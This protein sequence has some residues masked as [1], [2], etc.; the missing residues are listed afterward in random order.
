MTTVQG[1]VQER[2][3]GADENR[4]DQAEAESDV[5]PPP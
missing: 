2:T 1:G 4:Q 3:R 5:A